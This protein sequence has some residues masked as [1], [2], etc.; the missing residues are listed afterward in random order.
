MNIIQIGVGGFGRWWVEKLVDFPGMNLAAIVDVDD[1]ALEQAAAKTGLPD[2]CQFSDLEDAIEA[3]E[4]EL[5]ICVTPPTFH[6]QHTTTAMRAGLDAIVEKPL[7]VEMEDALDM[8]RTAQETGRLLAVSQNYRYRPPIWSMKKQV[9]KGAIGDIGQ[10]RLDFYKG[11]PFD[12]SDFRRTMPDVLLADMAIHHFDMMRFISGLEA[13]SVRGESWNPPWSLNEGD[14]SANVTFTMSNG[15][16]FVYN[17][18]WAAQGEYA[19]WNGNWLIEG[20]KGSLRLAGD[21]VE[22]RENAGGLQTEPPRTIRP[23]GPPIEDQSYVLAD[24]IAARAEG[25]Q[26]ATS[27]FD[28]LRSLGMVMA[29]REAVNSGKT[30]EMVSDF[31]FGI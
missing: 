12:P 22:W 26:P 11:W 1:A 25:R 7:A 16:R 5:L 31:G 27:V 15:A 2:S 29:A 20:E 30:V 23:S 10:L 8:A 17:A 4:A 13:A 6:K 18:S 19:G 9:A 14:S 3:V 28:N 24:M 21:D